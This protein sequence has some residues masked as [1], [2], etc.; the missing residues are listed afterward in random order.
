MIL[1]AGAPI[2]TR[3]VLELAPYGAVNPHC[4]ITPEYAGS[5]PTVWPLYDNRPFDIGYTIHFAVPQIDSGPIIE[6]ERLPWRTEWTFSTMACYLLQV[7]YERLALLVQQWAYSGAPPAEQPQHVSST[8]PPAGYFALR[9]AERRKA[10][11]RR[12]GIQIVIPPDWQGDFR[13]STDVGGIAF[14]SR[15]QDKIGSTSFRNT[16]ITAAS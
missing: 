14:G 6:Q 3:R 12:K 7:M 9:I 10:Q 16:T 11:L 2:L 15:W 4:G 1:L 5:S 8:R 13:T